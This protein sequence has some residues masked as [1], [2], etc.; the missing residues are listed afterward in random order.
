[1]KIYSYIIGWGLSREGELQEGVKPTAGSGLREATGRIATERLGGV[2][3][4]NI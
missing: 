4:G 3:L 2:L 1:M